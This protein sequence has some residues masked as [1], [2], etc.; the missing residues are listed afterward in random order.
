MC[1]SVHQK[2]GHTIVVFLVTVTVWSWH[3]VHHFGN[4]MFYNPAK[5]KEIFVIKIIIRIFGSKYYPNFIFIAHGQG[6][7]LKLNTWLTLK[8]NQLKLKV[9]NFESPLNSEWMVS[10][11]FDQD[12]RSCIHP[13]KL[14]CD[15]NFDVAKQIET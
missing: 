10:N 7:L 8:L 13:T 12:I 9:V 2:W 15:I 11:L 1:D 6:Y 14:Q 4:N 3:V 5:E